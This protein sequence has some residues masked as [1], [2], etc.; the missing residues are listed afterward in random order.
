MSKQ[1]I[2]LAGLLGVGMVASYMSWTSEDPTAD[3]EGVVVIDAKPEQIESI[4]WT[5]ETMDVELSRR[6]DAVGDYIWV[7]TIERIEK[8]IPAEVT[9]SPLDPD[10]PAPADGEEPAEPSEPEM[11]IE[12]ETVH[13]DFKAGDTAQELIESF[14]PLMASRRLEVAPDKYVDFGLDTPQATL[15]ITRSGKEPRELSIG[16]E[17][18]GTR[19]RYALDAD[20]NNVVLLDSDLLR[21]LKFA[22]SR[23]PDRDL[24]TVETPKLTKVTVSSPNREPVN[25]DQLNAADPQKATWAYLGET[26]GDESAAAWMN[27]ALSLKAKAYVQAEEMPTSTTTELTLVYMAEDGSQHQV[28][29][30]Q[31]TDAQGETQ[32]YGRSTN[33]RELVTLHAAQASELVAD[34][35]AL[36]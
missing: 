11:R 25:L 18:Y 23:L 14:A 16:G 34:L 6:S 30:I 21:P 26:E 24:L 29:V 17:A 36:P 5:S 2:I 9:V 1:V 33:T 19:D 32:W 35:D 28:E 27:K 15:V 8:E 20:K 7:K 12:T 31:G 13:R 4:A 22:I 10:A 3:T